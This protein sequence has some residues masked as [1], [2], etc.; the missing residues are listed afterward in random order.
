MVGAMSIWLTTGMC[1]CEGHGDLPLSDSICP[2]RQTHSW[3][4]RSKTLQNRDRIEYDGVVDA[5]LWTRIN[6]TP[7]IPAGR[8]GGLDQIGSL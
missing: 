4:I 8:I 3:Q 7:A 2:G 5:L 6:H 1:L